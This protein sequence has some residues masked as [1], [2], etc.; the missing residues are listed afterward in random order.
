MDGGAKR[1]GS[2][3]EGKKRR[4]GEKGRENGSGERE[5]SRLTKR[6]ERDKKY[7]NLS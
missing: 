7:E 1:P 3:G 2:V 4:G 6:A 5:V